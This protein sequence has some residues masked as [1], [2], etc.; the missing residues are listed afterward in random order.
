MGTQLCVL[1]PTE[2]GKKEKIYQPSAVKNGLLLSFKNYIESI[3]KDSTLT[4]RIY[5]ITHN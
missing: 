5:L 1:H 2:K 4:N 3:A